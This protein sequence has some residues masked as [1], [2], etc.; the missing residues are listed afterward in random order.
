MPVIQ[1]SQGPNA[2]DKDDLAVSRFPTLWF[3]LAFL[4]SLLL[5]FIF[6]GPLLLLEKKGQL[7]SYDA[8]LRQSLSDLF[9]YVVTNFLFKFLFIWAI[10]TTIR[11]RR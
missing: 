2:F 11:F 5:V 10:F 3:S 4:N 8:P 1:I 6:L 7:R 9:T